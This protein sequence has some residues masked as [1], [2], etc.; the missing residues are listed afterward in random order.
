MPPRRTIRGRSARRNVDPQDQEVP[1][2]PEVQ[3]QGED[4]ADTSRIRE[5]LRMNP[6]DFTSSSVTEDPENFVE[7]LQK[8]FEV[9]HVVDA[10]RVELA[11]YQLTGV[12]RVCYDQWKK[13]RA[14]GA[15]IC[16]QNGHF[17]RECLKNM[18]GVGNGGNRAQSSSLAPPNKATLRGATSGTGGGANLLYAITSR[19]E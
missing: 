19:Q 5:F 4:V 6:L 7:E 13:S 14:E 12:A 2:V 10:E 16:G 8:M 17:M 1:N 9:M 15:P 18:Q 3:L 11:A